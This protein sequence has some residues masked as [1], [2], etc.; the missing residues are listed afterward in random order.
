[1]LLF[2]YVRDKHRRSVPWKKCMMQW[3]MYRTKV[4]IPLY[5]SW[6]GKQ[7]SSTNLPKEIHL[8]RWY[9]YEQTQYFVQLVLYLWMQ[10]SCSFY[11]FHCHAHWQRSYPLLAGQLAT[12]NKVRTFIGRIINLVSEYF[13]FCLQIQNILHFVKY[14]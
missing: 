4:F 11:M 8:F 1:M 3:D 12:A 5:H 14:L 7:Y 2:N 13:I 6:Q 10:P 9:F